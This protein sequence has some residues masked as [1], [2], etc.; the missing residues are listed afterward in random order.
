MARTRKPKWPENVRQLETGRF[1]LQFEVTEHGVTRRLSQ[2]SILRSE[3]RSYAT[4]DEALEGRA[5]VRTFLA[6]TA[7]RHTTVLGFWER[8]TN[9]RDWR[10]GSEFTG[11]G[12][13]TFETNRRKTAAFVKRYGDRQIASVS[14]EDVKAHM[15]TG[16]GVT[17]LQYISLFF[18]DAMR[19]GLTQHNPADD[20]A[21]TAARTARDRRLN[22]KRR[23]KPPTS[24]QIR[25]MLERAAEPAYPRSIYGW[26]LAGS[27]TGMRAGELDAMEFA[28]VDGDVYHITQQRHYRTN[29]LEDPKHES[30]RSVHLSDDL[31]AEIERVRSED[32]RA[33]WIWRNAYG[34]WWRP[35][36]R[37][38]WWSWDGDGGPSLRSLVGDATMYQATRHHWAWHALNTL[39]ISVQKIARLYGHQD[40]GKTLLAHYADVDND[41]ALESVRAARAAAP[42]D[43]SA[44]RRRAA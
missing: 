18:R 16:V 23:T 17:Q 32:P 41:A 22:H 37:D 13:E 7:D 27:E 19:E 38:K 21:R 40:G 5:R 35:A 8:W 14:T 4:L 31:L 26:L 2:S 28:N 12:D 6:T 39:D 36:A 34:E 44:R 25:A 10:W 30:F 3:P 15:S 20:L 24:D 29:T 1:S 43:L 42:V 11:R 9:E 33:R